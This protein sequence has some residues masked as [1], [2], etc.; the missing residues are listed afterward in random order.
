MA[1]KKKVIKEKAKPK[2][3]KKQKGSNDR[4]AFAFVA[5][6]LSVIGFLIALIAK[7]DDKYVMFY[8]KQ[9][10]VIFVLA[11]I[12][13]IIV[14]AVYWIPVIGPIINV[15]L[16]ILVILAW[17]LSWAYALTGKQKEIPVVDH[18]TGKID[19]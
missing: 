9:S 8:A 3:S 17:I 14:K 15:A 10:L 12:S 4:I 19:L 16:S 2:N 11:V 18:W 1:A 7:K 6:F 5:T 13:A